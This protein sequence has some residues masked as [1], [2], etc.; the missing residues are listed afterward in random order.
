[1]I[2]ETLM[3]SDYMVYKRK[4]SKIDPTKHIQEL[5]GIRCPSCKEMANTIEHGTSRWCAGCGLKMTVWGNALE[6][7]KE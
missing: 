2:K 1:M 4:R 6:C 3:A 7:E 5:I